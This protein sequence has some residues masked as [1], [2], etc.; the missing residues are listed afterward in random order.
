MNMATRVMTQINKPN[1]V[2]QEFSVSPNQKRVAYLESMSNRSDFNLIIAGTNNQIYK[3]LLWEDNAGWGAFQWLDNEHLAIELLPQNDN[4]L[5]SYVRDFL[6]L[7]P[8]TG[9]RQILKTDYPN[10]YDDFPMP[11]WAG[12]GITAYNQNLTRAV[13]LERDA[14]G[15]FYYVLWDLQKKSQIANFQITGDLEAVVRWSSDGK[16][17]AFA[18]SLSSNMNEYPAYELF[19]VTKDG[20]TKQLTH[21]TD[22]FP[23]VYIADLSWSTDNRYIAFWYSHWEQN[24]DPSYESRGDRYLA[25]LDT[26]TDFVTSYCINGEKNGGIG[27]VIYPEPIW[28]PDS[29]Q[30]VI[31]SQISADSFQTVLI[32]VQKNQ[33][34]KLGDELAPAGWMVSP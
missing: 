34:Y 27:M 30:V 18:P 2:L 4:V 14:S 7:N 23:W 6:I 29:N 8:F 21:L 1:E 16:Q 9:E 26:K 5:V 3:T 33:A 32:D 12:W 22:Y 17:F 19:K 13:Y 31:Q 28:S 20:N 10:V 11:D 25:I 15:P 24:K